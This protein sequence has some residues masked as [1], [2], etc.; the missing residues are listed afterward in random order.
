MKT[1]RRSSRDNVI[2]SGTNQTHA[3][4][5]LLQRICSLYGLLIIQEVSWYNWR[6]FIAFVGN[7]KL[8]RHVASLS[9]S[10]HF[11]YRVFTLHLTK[12]S[13]LFELRHP[14]S[15]RHKV[16][17]ASY[18]VW[19]NQNNH[20]PAYPF[21]NSLLL[22]RTRPDSSIYRWKRACGLYERPSDASK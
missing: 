4:F 19:M 9:P 13:P 22:G 6:S 17:A 3:D 5:I 7:N 10:S 21:I 12:G 16:S 18:G 1:T 11:A 8:G 2:I 20:N 14:G 15:R